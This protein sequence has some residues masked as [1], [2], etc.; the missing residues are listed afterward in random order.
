MIMYG[1]IYLIAKD[2]EKSISFYKALFEK[3]VHAQNKTRFAV[4]DTN[5]LWLAIMN[6]RFDVEHPDEVLKKGER[7]A[8][9][10]NMEPIMG[11]ANC[12]KVVI[13]LN[14]EDLQAEYERIKS[15]D[16]GTN[17]TKIRY[18][19]AGRPYYYFCLK[20]PD[21]N[22]IEITGSFHGKIDE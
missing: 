19:N 5:G 4:F 8:L 10:D 9:Y 12:G 3:D 6:G 22:T 18:I 11:T 1:S 16:I 2:F 20:D 7:C 15:L 14:T 13:N 21:G 17:L